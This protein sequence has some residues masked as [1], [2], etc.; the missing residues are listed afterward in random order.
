MCFPTFITVI[1][2]L[3][4][5]SDVHLLIKISEKIIGPLMLFIQHFIL[6]ENFFWFYNS[7]HGKNCFPYACNLLL[8]KGITYENDANRCFAL[9]IYTYMSN[10]YIYVGGWCNTVK[11]DG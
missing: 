2:L 4:K 6:R 1:I 7:V 5:P 3:E 10:I 11:G 9:D 8:Y